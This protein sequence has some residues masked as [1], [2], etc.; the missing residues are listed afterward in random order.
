M[1]NMSRYEPLTKCAAVEPQKAPIITDIAKGK[2]KLHFIST[3]FLWIKKPVNA[4]TVLTRSADPNAVLTAKSILKFICRKSQIRNGTIKVVPPMPTKPAI[5][6]IDPPSRINDG[7]KTKGFICPSMPFT[8]N[9]IY[10][11]N[12]NIQN[13][14]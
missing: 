6:P 5:N 7:N 3:L 2:I 4:V 10:T 14:I 1:K 9:H 12:Q 13:C 8:P 11:M